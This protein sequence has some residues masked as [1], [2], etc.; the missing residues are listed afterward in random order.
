MRTDLGTCDGCDVPLAILHITP[1]GRYCGDCHIAYM[2]RNGLAG[3]K[4]DGEE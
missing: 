4:K 3:F 2:K 1:E